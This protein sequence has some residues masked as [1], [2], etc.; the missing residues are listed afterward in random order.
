MVYSIYYL[1]KNVSKFAIMIVFKDKILFKRQTE[2]SRFPILK[3]LALIHL[4]TPNNYESVKKEDVKN[5][6]IPNDLLRYCDLYIEMK[7]NSKIP[8]ILNVE[9]DYLNHIH[10]HLSSY[11]NT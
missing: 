8:I 3:I 5:I 1:R 2:L 10:M 4:Y 6:I 11:L 9:K 7:D